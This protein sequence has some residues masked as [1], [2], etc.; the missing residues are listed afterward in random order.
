VASIL[1]DAGAAV[2]AFL[3]AIFWFLSAVVEAPVD[4]RPQEDSDGYPRGLSRSEFSGRTIEVWET[5]RLRSKWAR[6]AA[7]AAAGA[8]AFQCA[9]LVLLIA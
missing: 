6:R 1:L 4:F 2:F 5:G 3:A 9:A 7:L 8:A